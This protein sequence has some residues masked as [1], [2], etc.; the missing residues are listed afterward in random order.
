MANDIAPA[1]LEKVS[2]SFD[3]LTA[4]D[5]TLSRLQA[6]IEAGKGTYADAQAYATRAGGLLSEAL[7]RY[8][9]SD[10]LPDGRMYYNIAD[11]LLTPLLTSDHDLVANAAAQVQQTLNEAAGIGMQA[12]RP[13]LNTDRIR[14]LVDEVS[15]AERY[16]DVSARL[17]GQVTNFSQN[18]V[19]ESVRVNADAQ[20]GAGMSPKITRI[21]APNCCDWCADLAG[22]YEYTEVSDT[23]NE[24]WQR[25][26]NCGCLIEY[27][28]SRG[29]REA[30]Q[31]YRRSDQGYTP[32]K[33][34]DDLYRTGRSPEQIEAR[35]AQLQQLA[36]DR[37]AV[38]AEARQAV[39]VPDDR[40][41]VRT[42]AAYDDRQGVRDISADPES[43]GQSAGAESTNP[44][45]PIQVGEVRFSDKRAVMSNLADAEHG[46]VSLPY[47]VNTTVTADGKVWRTEGEAGSVNPSAIPSS[48]EGS[49]SYHNHTA[50]KT[51]YSFSAEDVS[52]FFESGQAYSRASDELYGYVMRR[53]PETIDKSPEWVYHRFKEIE[54]SDVFALKFDSLID[55]DLDSYHEVMKRLSEELKFDY[56]R[57]DRG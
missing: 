29:K 21:A 5:P 7:R 37:Q 16:D 11:R 22:T 50:E 19:D 31:N 17:Y 35:R 9:S 51:H 56:A 34:E 52:F 41:G 8:V 33:V 18:V 23:G 12:V 44:G 24:V 28:P 39:S 40:Q 45:E 27:V 26:A 2:A 43:R 55:P 4:S 15:S 6:R 14:G 48:L 20:F 3:A 1:L 10:D 38:K 30:V 46:S 54:D 36:D 25:H 13:S 49:Y 53:T 47:E 57:Y 32:N 42:V